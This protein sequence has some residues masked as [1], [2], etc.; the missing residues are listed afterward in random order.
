MAVDTVTLKR[1][2]DESYRG[3][4]ANRDL[5]RKTR[6]YYYGDQIDSETIEIV[7]DRGQPAQWEN[8][9]KKMGEKVLAFRGNHRGEIRM[10]GRQRQDDAGARLL[11]DVLRAISQQSDYEMQSD[12][13][14]EALMIGGCAVHELMIEE[15]RESTDRFGRTAKDVKIRHVPYDRLGLDPFAGEPDYSD[16]RYIHQ[17]YWVDREDLYRFFPAKKVDALQNGNFTSEISNDE[18]I[19]DLSHRDRVPLVYTWYRMYDRKQKRDRYYYCFWSDDIILQQDESP[20]DFDGFP[21]V[22]EFVY[23]HKELHYG[24]FNDIIPLQDAINYAKLRLQNMLGSVKILVEK[25]AVDDVYNFTMEYREDDAVVEVNDITKIKEIH[26]NSDVQQLIGVIMDSRQQIKEIIGANDEFLAMANNRLSGEAI[27]KRMDIG[28]MGI[29]RFIKASMRLQRR[30]FELAAKLVQQFYDS[31]RV[32]QIVE[33][34]EGVRYFTVNETQTDANG[35]PVLDV[36][37]DGSVMPVAKHDFRFGKYDLIFTHATKPATPSAERL[38]QS[39][40]L[41]KVLQ[42]TDPP[43]VKHLVP[44]ILKDMQSPAAEKMAQIVAQMEQAKAQQGPDQAQIAAMKAQLAEANAKI[45]KMQ[46][47]AQLNVAKAKSL[48]TKASLDLAGLWTKTAIEKEKN[49]ARQERSV[50][51]TIG[52]RFR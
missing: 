8:N 11:T 46:S 28:S 36:K 6:D 23:R 24:I 20:Y 13:S 33:P 18:D 47:E 3:N 22:V 17:F 19:D 32:M 2:L 48:E 9:M 42:V 29:N 25:N 30:T 26:Q 12:M 41:L 7:T 52:G 35:F 1:W 34:D 27:S 44:E 5:E 14:D 21:M 51:Q 39:T 4:D 15:D 37:E 10:V 31:E 45:A 49:V 38:R 16:A 40:E 50:G 43:L